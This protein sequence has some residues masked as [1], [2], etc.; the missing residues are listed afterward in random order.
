MATSSGGL[1]DF[2]FSSDPFSES[3]SALFSVALSRG[4]SSPG[5]GRPSTSSACVASCSTDSSSCVPSTPF[6]LTKHTPPPPGFRCV[7]APGNGSSYTSRTGIARSL[8]GRPRCFATSA[9]HAPSFP[10]K[11]FLIRSCASSIACLCSGHTFSRNPGSAF[12]SAA[13]SFIAPARSSMFFPPS[14][15]TVFRVFAIASVPSCAVAQS[16]IRPST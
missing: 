14:I 7:T 4:F 13:A 5:A 9:R 2:S 1:S 16:P 6:T 15:S 10:S 8:D 12:S 3:S 11:P